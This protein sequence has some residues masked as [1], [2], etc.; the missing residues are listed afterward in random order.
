MYSNAW[1]GSTVL[2]QYPIVE[3][4]QWQL[5]FADTS[6]SV[7]LWAPLEQRLRRQLTQLASARAAA[8]R[9]PQLINFIAS[10]LNKWQ[11]VAQHRQLRFEDQS[12]Q[13]AAP[14]PSMF[15]EVGRRRH[16]SSSAAGS[17]C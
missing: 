8:M 12:E 5:R 1:I 2:P 9:L 15:V 10:F 4:L 11:E 14:L 16:H 3:Q 13:T 6:I 17:Q 7:L